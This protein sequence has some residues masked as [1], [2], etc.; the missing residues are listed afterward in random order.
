MYRRRGKYRFSQ[1]EVWNLDYYLAEIILIGLKQFKE[2]NRHGY[3]SCVE[4]V[5]C[6]DAGVNQ[7]ELISKWEEILDKMIWS[8]DQIV[9]DRKDDPLDIYFSQRRDIDVIFESKNGIEEWIEGINK[10]NKRSIPDDVMKAHTEYNER[11]QE[12]LVLFGKYFQDLW[13]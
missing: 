3:P 8:F 4:G 9:N 6:T 12:G 1:K 5:Y 10:D 2:G 7:K 13:D 11:V